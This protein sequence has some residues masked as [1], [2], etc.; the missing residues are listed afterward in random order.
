MN[1]AKIKVS[2]PVMSKQLLVQ[3]T[4][5]HMENFTQSFSLV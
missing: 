4:Y 1:D 5:Q 2:A 3:M